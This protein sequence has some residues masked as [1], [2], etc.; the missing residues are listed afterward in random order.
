MAR[1]KVQD[2]IKEGRC[3]GPAVA[4]RKKEPAFEI[5]RMRAPGVSRCVASKS[6]GKRSWL[7]HKTDIY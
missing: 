6:I 5:P 7:R 2:V 1:E 3:G 4:G